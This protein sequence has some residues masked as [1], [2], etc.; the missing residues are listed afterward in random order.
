MC[1]ARGQ[2]RLAQPLGFLKLS[3]GLGATRRHPGESRGPGLP[4]GTLAPKILDSG[5]RRNDV[6]KR[7]T[8]AKRLIQSRAPPWGAKAKPR[9]LHVDI[10]VLPLSHSR[11]AQ[12]RTWSENLKR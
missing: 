3:R 10:Y 6:R 9:A 4:G 1:C 11:P 2:S 5:F 8:R 7:R 12:N